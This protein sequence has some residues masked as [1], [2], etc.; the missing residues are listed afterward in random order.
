[1]A[2]MVVPEEEIVCGKSLGRRGM[3]LVCTSVSRLGGEKKVS[4]VSRWAAEHHLT[5]LVSPF[6]TLV[7]MLNVSV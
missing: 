5:P 6:L 2:S 4:V 7:L 3:L 1:M